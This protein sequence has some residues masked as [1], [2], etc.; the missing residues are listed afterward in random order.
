LKIAHIV[1]EA[2]R[3]DGSGAALR[4]HAVGLGLAGMGE[5]CVIVMQDYFR[6]GKRHPA[7]RRSFL[8]AD[9]PADVT[10]DVAQRIAVFEADMVVVDGVYLAD[11]AHRFVNDGGHVILDMHNVESVLLKEID[12]A[13]RKWRALLLYRRRWARAALAEKAIAESVAGIWVCSAPDAG[14]VR[15]IV[16]H[17]KAIDVIPNP[18]PGWCAAAAQAPGAEPWGVRAL[19]VGHLGYRPNIVAVSRLMRRIMPRVRTAY[20]DAVLTICGRAPGKDLQKLA[21]DASGVRIIGNPDDL[22]P[23]YRDATVAVIPLTEG[24][25]T[26]LKVL[27]AMAL[28]VPVIATAKAVEGLELVAGQSYLA[29]E[30]DA[31]FVGAIARLTNDAPLRAAMTSEARRFVSVHHRQHAVDAAI[32]TAIARQGLPKNDAKAVGPC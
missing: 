30:T 6:D 4:N 20:P 23:Y 5:I 19:F 15:D 18:V 31:D 3:A 2:P 13:R 17:G 16:G 7:R 9:I 10:D 12:L 32:V 21:K 25:G 1:F 27:E 14:L 11:I 22:A 8:V 28:G 24:G 26:R 29:A